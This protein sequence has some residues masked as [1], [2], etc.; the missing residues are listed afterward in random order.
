M[1]LMLWNTASAC[2]VCGGAGQNQQAFLETMVF[3]TLTPLIGL[4]VAGT[5]FYVL[6]RRAVAAAEADAERERRDSAAVAR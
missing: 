6:W 5:A 1:A 2:A 3:M 4:G